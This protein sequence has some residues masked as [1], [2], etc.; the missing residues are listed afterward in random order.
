MTERPTALVIGG[1][2][3]GITAACEL[4]DA[5]VR[6]RLIEKCPYLGGRSYSYDAGGTEVDNG[7]HVFLGCCT[8]YIRL[9]ERLGVRDRVHLQKRMRV[10]VIDK[11]WGES[12][13]TAVDLPPP[14]HLLP[15][16]LRFKSLS[17][18]EKALAGYAF[19]Q[20]RQ[21]DRA[22]QPQLDEIT[23]EDWLLARKQSPHAIRSLWNLIIQPTLN[24]HVSRV[25]ADLALMVFQ[26]GFLR[27]RDGA[28][29][30]W[31]KVGLSTLLGAAARSYIESR[32]GEVLTTVGLQGVEAGADGV[33]RALTDA[34]EFTADAY[35]V[36]LPSGSVLD[37]LPEAIYDDPFFSRIRR[38]ETS[39]I[40]NVHLWYD[41]PV[42]D[43]TFAAFL[44]TPVQWLFNKSRI[45]GLN[46]PQYLDVSLSGAREW[47][48]VPAAEIR[49]HFAKELRS[50]LPRA[51]GAKLVKALVVKQRD[52]TLAPMPGVRRLR[53]T[54]ATPVRNLFLAGDWTDTGWPATMESAVRSGAAAAAAAMRSLVP[55]EN[56]VRA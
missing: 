2:L 36:A 42:W 48:H 27:S 18:A 3:A 9:V 38:I 53:P 6:V 22:A 51:R 10:P 33:T 56:A 49:D 44:N 52:A 11:V 34:G 41:R 47:I 26:E 15:S 30:G 23:F 20:I 43:R 39:P 46:G 35:V 16:L 50:L 17:P 32:E 21:T 7:Q 25:S 12:V 14:A 40:V 1:G 29:V 8:E 13:L 37:V 45:W 54:Q 55:R 24:D 19:A 28:N 5:G 4:A 31:A